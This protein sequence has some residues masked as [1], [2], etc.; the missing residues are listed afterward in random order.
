MTMA[1]DE[2]DQFVV[3]V[4]A[5]IKKGNQLLIMKR[6]PQRLAAPSVWETVSGRVQHEEDPYDAVQREI[7]EE[8]GL[9]VVVDQRPVDVYMAKR[10]GLPMLLIVYQAKYLSKE[11]I[12]SEEHSEF[13][14]TTLEEFEEK[15]PLKKL[16]KAARKAFELE[17]EVGS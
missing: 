17:T 14:W 16:V 5:I 6:S 15:T 8:T 11:V 9:E 10:L 2:S 1:E 12:L 3:A 4:V 13:M 7:L